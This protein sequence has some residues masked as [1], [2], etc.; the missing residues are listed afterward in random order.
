MFLMVEYFPSNQ[1]VENTL[2]YVSKNNYLVLVKR[3]IT[4]YEV[5]KA[6]N[7][8]QARI[9]TDH[10]FLFKISTTWKMFR[11]GTGGLTIQPRQRNMV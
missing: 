4:A 8:N 7:D 6:K 2:V 5:Y 10:Y 3:V 9:N 11:D 1:L